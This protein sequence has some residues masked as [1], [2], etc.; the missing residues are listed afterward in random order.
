MRGVDA[1]ELGQVISLAEPM[2]PGSANGVRD[3]LRHFMVRDGGDFAASKRRFVFADDVIAM[4][5]HGE[6][7]L[8]ALAHVLVDGEMWNGFS[9]DLVTSRGAQRCGIETAGPIVT[10]GVLADLVP[11]GEEALPV[12][13]AI[14]VDDL[15]RAVDATGIGPEPGDALFVRTGWPNVRRPGRDAAWRSPGLAAGCAEWIDAQGF[16]LVA[17]DNLAVEVLP[18]TDPADIA[19]LHVALSRDRGILLAELLN[20]ETLMRRDRHVFLAV[21]APLPL[22]GAVGSPVAPVAVI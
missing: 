14:A 3:P 17:A 20:F 4:P 6:T 8:D 15:A 2:T 9:S 19:P 21:I 1:I 16:C 5:T 11:P 18:P 12:G 7:H 13:T 10:R 22:V